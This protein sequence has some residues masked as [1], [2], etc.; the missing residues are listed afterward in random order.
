MAS[1]NLRCTSLI[2]I[3]LFFV[4]KRTEYFNRFLIFDTAQS[5]YTLEWKRKDV[6]YSI[7]R[8]YVNSIYIYFRKL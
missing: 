2:L 8:F 5:A 1:G 3:F 7:T 4:L 6:S